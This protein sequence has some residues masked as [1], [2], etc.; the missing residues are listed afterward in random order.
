MG[1]VV[2][3]LMSRGP[4]RAEASVADGDL[5]VRQAGTDRFTLETHP[6][7]PQVSVRSYRAALRL[8]RGFAKTTN[9]GIW[10]V[11][12]NGHFKKVKAAESS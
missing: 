10:F 8:A 4:R 11:N 3:V 12:S 2:D 1:A 6:E 5:V 7:R 9:V